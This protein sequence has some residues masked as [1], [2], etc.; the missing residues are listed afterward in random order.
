MA[1]KVVLYYFNGRGK[2]ESIRWLLTA[3]E[4]EF[5]EV[6]LTTRDQYEKLLADGALM[7]E[8]VPMVEIDGMHL[9]QTRAILM[10]IAE[11]YKLNGKDIKE[12]AMVN[13][14]S[15]GLIDLMEMI[16]I[17]PFTPPADVKAKLET[18]ETKAT[19][20]YLPVFEKALCGPVFLVGG[21]L[22][23]ADVQLMECSLMLEE[24]F[25]GVL[26]KFPNI[27]V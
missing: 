13:M 26:A 18:I 16:M 3:A 8:Q 10:Y 7:F 6:H 17:L 15:E 25:P 23:V 4:V 21:Q 9:V 14:Y 1:E 24:K 11:K 12:R 22:S 27:K 5:D 2:M 19:G 20:R